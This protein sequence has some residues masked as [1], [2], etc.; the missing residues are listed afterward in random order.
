MAPAEPREIVPQ[1]V[2]QEAHLAIGLDAER[3]V[4]LRKLC[5]VGSVDQ[6][7]MGHFGHGPVERLVDLGLAGGV[8][9]VVD[10]ADDM[11]HPHVVVVDDDREHI[12]RRAVR[13]EQHE[14]VEILVRDDDAALHEVVDDGLALARG[15]E[16]DRG[17]DA[18]RGVGGRAVAPPAVIARRAAFGLRGRAHLLE[19]FGARVAAIGAP[20]AEHLLDRLAVAFGARELEGRLAVPVEAEPLQP[21]EDRVDRRVSRAGAVGVLDAQQ[22]LAAEAL[23]EQPVEQRGARPPDV[24]KAGR[25]RRETGDDGF[26]HRRTVSRIGRSRGRATTRAG[27]TV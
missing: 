14:I 2:G 4:A 10:A 22:H 26:G 27:A 19:F 11:R 21:V 24:Q 9:Q 3:A 6:W 18:F 23:G 25:R 17:L 1:R 12:G 16:A 15:L 8:R 13:A 5:A 20:L 7:D